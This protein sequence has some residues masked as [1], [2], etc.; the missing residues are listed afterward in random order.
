M[1]VQSVF[2][3]FDEEASLL[4]YLRQEHLESNRHDM[5]SVGFKTAL[6]STLAEASSGLASAVE[7]LWHLMQERQMLRCQLQGLMLR[8]LEQR[9]GSAFSRSFFT[10]FVRHTQT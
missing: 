3:L 4:F 2:T 7:L 1:F 6:P 9:A 10:V 5:F 8:L